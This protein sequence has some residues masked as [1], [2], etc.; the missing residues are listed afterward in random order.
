MQSISKFE[1]ICIVMRKQQESK[2]CYLTLV[3]DLDKMEV[4]SPETPYLRIIRRT[5]VKRT[6]KGFDLHDNQG[7]Q[8]QFEYTRHYREKTIWI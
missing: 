1:C 5:T 8:L 7:K 2:M 4:D 3:V 6:L